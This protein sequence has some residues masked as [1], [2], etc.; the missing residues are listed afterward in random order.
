M[1]NSHVIG[2]RALLKLFGQLFLRIAANR[3]VT[4]KPR[5]AVP[6]REFPNR[7]EIAA[8][9]RPIGPIA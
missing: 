3:W 6:P 5:V 7:C 2:A 1:I 9:P 4:A 8:P